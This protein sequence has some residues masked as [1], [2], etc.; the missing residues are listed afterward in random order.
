M[1]NNSNV[2]G[3]NLIKSLLDSIPT[4]PG[5]YRMLDCNQQILY[6]GKAKNL[7]KRLANYTKHDLTTKIT[8]MIALISDIEYTITSSEVEALLLEAQLIKKW[9]PKFNILLKDDKSFPYIK[10]RLDH[11]YPQLIKYRGQDLTNGKFFGPFTSSSQIDITLLELQKIF[12]LRSCTDNFYANRKRPCLQYQI[13]RCYAPCVNKISAPDYADLVLQV[14]DFLCGKTQHLQQRLAQNMEILSANLNFEAAAEI[15]DRIKALSYIQLK[16]G[17][18]INEDV[19]IIAIAEIHGHYC[20]AVFLYRGGQSCGSKSY[21]PYIPEYSNKVEVL[22]AFLSQFYHTHSPPKAIILSDA[23]PQSGLLAESIN[24]LH[25]TKSIIIIPKGGIKR[26]LVLNAY[27]NAQLALEQNIQKSIKHQ[28]IFA[29]IRQL[30]GL[31]IVPDRIEVYDNSHIMGEFAVGAMIVATPNGFDKKE[32]RLFNI[33]QLKSAGDAKI[34]DDYQMLREVMTRRL[35]RLRKDHTKIPSLIIIDGGKGHLSVVQKIMHE[36]NLS[37]P[38]VCMSKGL[39]RNAGHE[40][41]HLPNQESF[42][43]DNQTLLMKYLQIL[44]DE[45]HNF[46]INAHRAKRSNA[47]RISKL[48]DIPNIGQIRKKALLN[49]FGSYQTI[50]EATIDQLSQVPGI[51]RRVATTIFNNLHLSS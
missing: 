18:T 12:K 17:A 3:H 1:A 44:R 21:F 48:D 39:I 47:I 19:D 33:S 8:I 13:K 34:G 45:A 16:S 26:D 7:R 15:R 50:C 22:T 4:L 46:A 10:L 51:N 28:T 43:L 29:E 41:F 35:T 37:I 20:I 23:I 25:Q 24:K 38:F 31:K 2:T 40:Q 11:D 49:Y 9:Q 36:F 32:Y 5:I 27:T 14:Q 6:I 42:T 30:F